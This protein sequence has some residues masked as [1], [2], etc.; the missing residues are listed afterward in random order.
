MAKENMKILDAIA[1]RKPAYCAATLEH[2]Y[3]E[4]VSRINRLSR[5]RGPATARH[6]PTQVAADT[7]VAKRMRASKCRPGTAGYQRDLAKSMT[8]ARKPRCVCSARAKHLLSPAPPPRRQY[9]G[10][11]SPVQ[12]SFALRSRMHYTGVSMLLTSFYAR[13]GRTVSGQTI[14]LHAPP[15]S[16]RQVRALLHTP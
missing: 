9:C 15:A 11:P 4:N 6:L 12:C 1:T 7:E 3:I 8:M 5:F 13:A 10:W 2:E 16:T 14:R